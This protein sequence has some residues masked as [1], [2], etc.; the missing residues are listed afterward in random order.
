[1]GEKHLVKIFDFWPTV[2]NAIGLKLL[3]TLFSGQTGGRKLKRRTCPAIGGYLA[4]LIVWLHLWTIPTKKLHSSSSLSHVLFESWAWLDSKFCIC[5]KNSPP[6][7][8]KN[9]L[10]PS[11]QTQSQ[12]ARYHLVTQKVLA[13]Q[14]FL[15]FDWFLAGNCLGVKRSEQITTSYQNMRWIWSKISKMCRSM[16]QPTK[17]I[18][19][20]DFI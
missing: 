11:L 13:T 7:Q 4:T 17:K 8:N 12:F 9:S 1:L 5:G 15:G 3:S 14:S 18:L 6:A 10:H 16:F 20:R 19:I 2:K